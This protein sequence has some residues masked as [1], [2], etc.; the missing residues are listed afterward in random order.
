MLLLVKKEYAGYLGTK[1]GEIFEKGCMVV[2]A[3]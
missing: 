1:Q 3:A 2:G